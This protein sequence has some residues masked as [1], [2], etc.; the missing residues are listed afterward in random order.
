M[1]FLRTVSPTVELWVLQWDRKSLA[2]D[3]GI[4]Q[5]FAQTTCESAELQ[6]FATKQLRMSTLQTPW[7]AILGN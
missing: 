4:V 3:E 6:A 2:S 1:I 7:K 5:T